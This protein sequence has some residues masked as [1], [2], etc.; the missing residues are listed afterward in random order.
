M[1]SARARVEALVGGAAQLADGATELGQR[2][3]RELTKS[4]GLS[5]ESVAW[6]LEQGLET[7]PSAAEL[8]ALC[9]SVAE[10]HAV[11]VV[12]PANVFV[13]AHRAIALGLAASARVFVRPSR[14]EP[15]F[16]ELLGAAAPGLFELVPDIA[17]EPGDAV[18]AYGGDASLEA[19]R[20]RLAG[21]V[22]LH[23]QGPGFGVAVVAASHVGP[24]AARALAADIVPFEQRG[25]L[26]PRA[27]MVL[28]GQTDAL[29]FGELLAEA[30]RELAV[31]IPPGRLDDAERADGARFR[32]TAAYAGTLLDAGPGVVFVAENGRPV[33]APVGRNL[34]VS[35]ALG[36]EATLAALDPARLV[37]V[38]VAGPD[39][40]TQKI[41]ST[42]GDARVSPLGRMQRPR[43]DGPVDRRPTPLPTAR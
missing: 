27:A 31:R 16:A 38:G 2:A 5:A 19:I 36:L 30:L 10:A 22:Q 33:V 23:A 29:R 39:D 35:R 6:A 37:A 12:L 43:F 11:H 34:H 18:W 28:G 15:H 1:T 8:D 3:R 9:A 17:P 4:T 40:L 42:L 25:C 20:A 21:G 7:A 24:E 26:S 32:D 41:Q 13:A 14:R